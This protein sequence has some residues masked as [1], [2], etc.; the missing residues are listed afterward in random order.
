MRKLYFV[1]GLLLAA[2]LANAQMADN[3]IGLRLAGGNGFGT[4][5]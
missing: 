5:I 3:A 2:N 1:L 4:E